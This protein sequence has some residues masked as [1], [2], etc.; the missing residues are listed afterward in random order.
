MVEKQRYDMDENKS[1]QKPNTMQK[2]GWDSDMGVASPKLWQQKERDR[3]QRE[4]WKLLA[5]SG[6][7]VSF[8]TFCKVFFFPLSLSM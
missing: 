8:A 1:P 7:R 2:I 4:Q 6:E 3:E 5:A